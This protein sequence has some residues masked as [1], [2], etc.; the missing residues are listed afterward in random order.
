MVLERK[1]A[2][3]LVVSELE[4]ALLVVSELE[5]VLQLVVLERKAALQLVVSEHRA[6]S[7]VVEIEVA[8]LWERAWVGFVAGILVV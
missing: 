3:Q 6:A 5:V 2:L 4:V 1:A 7:R 8:L